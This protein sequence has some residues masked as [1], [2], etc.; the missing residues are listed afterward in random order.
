MGNYIDNEYLQC[1]KLPGG[2]TPDL[3]AYTEDE[4]SSLIEKYESLVE[5]YTNDIFYSKTATYYFDG[6]GR[7]YLYFW[8]VV[9]YNILT[10]T[11]VEDVNEDGSQVL[12]EYEEDVDYKKYNHHIELFNF[13]TTI[14]TSIFRGDG[15]PKGQKNIKVVGTW[16]WSETPIAIKDAVAQLVI[17][18]VDPQ[19]INLTS[20]NGVQRA[21][22][23]DFEIEFTHFNGKINPYSTGYL[24]I[25]RILNR[26]VNAE[27]PFST[28]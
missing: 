3:S 26:Y 6:S 9:P 23:D 13:E 21:E 20:L 11:S 22:W 5:N 1:Y 10:I 12:T 16:G 25:D 19:Q 7:Y 24:E 8:P 15:W 14:R 28:T 17:K 2:I 4:L 18:E 27:L